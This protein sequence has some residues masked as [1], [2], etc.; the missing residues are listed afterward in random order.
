[1]TAQIHDGEDDTDEDEY[2]DEVNGVISTRYFLK[3]KSETRARLS[4]TFAVLLITRMQQT[5]DPEN[6]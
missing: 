2:D 3:L 1:M 5:K 4:S 6:I